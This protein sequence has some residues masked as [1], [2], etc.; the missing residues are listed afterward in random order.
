VIVICGRKRKS[1]REEKKVRKRKEKEV[2][3]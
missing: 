2:A 1:I 3:L